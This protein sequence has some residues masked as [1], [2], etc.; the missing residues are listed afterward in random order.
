MTIGETSVAGAREYIESALAVAVPITVALL[1]TVGARILVRRRQARSPSPVWF[2]LQRRCRR[3]FRIVVVTTAIVIALPAVGLP[4]TLADIIRHAL[5]LA[6]IAAVTWLLIQLTGVVEDVASSRLD[7]AVS[8]NR[9]SRRITTQILV[10]R[11]VAIAVL[12][13]IGIAAGAMTIP[14]AR[15]LGASFLVSAGVLGVVAGL[16]A[17]T[18]LTN[19]FAGIQIAVADPIRID[20]VVV[21]HDEWG[22]IEEITL[23]YVV[24]RTW[25]NRRLI[26]P[27]SWFTTNVFQN[28]T[29]DEARVLG[30]IFLHVDFRA[31]VEDLRAEMYRLVQGSP[32]WDGRD[33]VL[34]VVDTTPTTMVVRGLVSSADAPSNWD[35]RCDV[36]EKLLLFLQQHHPDALPRVRADVSQRNAFNTMAHLTHRSTA[37]QRTRET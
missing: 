37:D 24:V 12:V 10:L 21:V 20:D 5:V 19:L 2:S 26:L 1:V 18:T 9:Q 34:Q 13:F 8:D 35:L 11:R 25:D 3:P 16:A 30:S 7:L 32:L 14:W 15:A 29:R 4:A 23:T 36:R 27:I 33:W 28:W 17:Q 31:S 6:L 22:R